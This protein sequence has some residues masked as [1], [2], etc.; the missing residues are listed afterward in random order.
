MEKRKSRIRGDKKAWAVHAN[1]EGGTDIYIDGPWEEV[2]PNAG[3]WSQHYWTPM[4]IWNFSWAE[5][6]M[7]WQHPPEIEFKGWVFFP[8]QMQWVPNADAGAAEEWEWEVP[9]V[10]HENV[11]GV[12]F[13][14]FRRGRF[15]DVFFTFSRPPSTP[16]K[17]KKKR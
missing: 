2:G 5:I 15:W 17:R 13:L 11:Q 3:Q 16:R 1:Y 12:F 14:R 9:L 8:G 7:G 6:L 10:F 4:P